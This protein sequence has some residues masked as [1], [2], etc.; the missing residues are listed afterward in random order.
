M[1]KKNIKCEQA[2]KKN[3]HKKNEN[4]IIAQGFLIRNSSQR[5]Y[6]K[7]ESCLR[8]AA[9]DRVIGAESCLT[10]SNSSIL[11]RDA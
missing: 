1:V 7:R 5:L 2:I 10:V 4:K 11:R 9:T 3:R 8:A 6:D